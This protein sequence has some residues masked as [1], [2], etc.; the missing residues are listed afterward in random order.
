MDANM[1]NQAL[2]LALMEK[3]ASETKPGLKKQT[4][5]ESWLC[6]LADVSGAVNK[7]F[8]PGCCQSGKPEKKTE[9]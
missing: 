5:Q 7:A 2:T 8:P 6:L 1:S 9:K 3:I 4:P